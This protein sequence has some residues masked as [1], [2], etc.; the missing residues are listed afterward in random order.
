M[1]T[2]DRPAVSADTSEQ[3]Q[4]AK[5]AFASLDI[6][7]E[8]IAELCGEKPGWFVPTYDELSLFLM[9]I[10]IILLYAMNALMREQIYYSMA[11]VHDVRV[12]AVASFF[13]AACALVSI[14]FSLQGRQ[15]TLRKRL[16]C[17]SRF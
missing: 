6:Q 2:K 5:E 17:S 15:L 16:C 1:T 13:Y 11:K 4:Q 9:A 8:N 3:V 14:T 12:Y 7:S 10:T